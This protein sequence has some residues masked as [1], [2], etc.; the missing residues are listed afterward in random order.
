[1][2]S[3]CGVAESRECNA[4]RPRLPDVCICMACKARILSREASRGICVGGFTRVEGRFKS[5]RPGEI[6]KIRVGKDIQEIQAK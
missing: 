2:Q 4:H 3:A 1:M 5:A 6:P